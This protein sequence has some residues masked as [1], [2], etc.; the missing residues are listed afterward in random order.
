MP[1][2]YDSDRVAFTR[3]I[4]SAISGK[5][6]NL[7]YPTNA[8]PYAAISGKPIL[9]TVATSGSYNDLSNKPTIPTVPTNVSAFTND[10][11]SL[12]GYTE[13]DPTIKSW[14]KAETKPTY[15]ASEVGATTPADVTAAIREQSRGGIW[16]AELD[17]WW[18]PRMK[19][20]SLT[21]EA[22][23]NVNLNAGN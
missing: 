13:S 12:T 19:N 9:A 20:G 6:D 5:Q 21:Y 10:A 3:D 14:A 4:D 1:N 8:I 15:T 2:A 16:D 18:T 23:T 17:V 7:P 11:G 22:T